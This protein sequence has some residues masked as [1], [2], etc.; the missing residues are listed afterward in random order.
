MILNKERLAVIRAY[1]FEKDG[2]R[3]SVEDIR[4]LLD[5]LLAEHERAER[6]EADSSMLLQRVDEMKPVFNA[7]LAWANA[8]EGG[9]E[10]NKLLDFI[11]DYESG[12]NKEHPP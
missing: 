11:A 5:T 1:I 7:A 12:R 9:P 3:L 10:Q 8:D 6:A 2:N 4:D